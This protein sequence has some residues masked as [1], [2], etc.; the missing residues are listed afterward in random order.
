MF[1]QFRASSKR[2]VGVDDVVCGKLFLS[3]S[4]SRY[5]KRNPLSNRTR[6][7]PR[8]PSESTSTIS[9]HSP[10]S[11]DRIDLAIRTRLPTIRRKV[12]SALRR[13]SFSTR[14]NSLISQ[15]IPTLAFGRA[16]TAIR[17]GW[18]SFTQMLFVDLHSVM[19]NVSKTFQTGNL[20]FIRVCSR[21]SVTR[22]TS[23]TFLDAG[24]WSDIIPILF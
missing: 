3:N 24:Y 4:S 5:R 10:G 20:P 6:Y 7:A 17:L 1:L 12:D 9:P 8:T 15:Y 22:A 19:P 18:N 16:A 23:P 14:F 11:G 2:R 13:N 21:I